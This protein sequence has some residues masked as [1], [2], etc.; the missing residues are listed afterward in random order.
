MSQ[1]RT[2]TARL[3]MFS[4]TALTESNPQ[5]NHQ[6]NPQLNP[7]LNDELNHQRHHL[8][9]QRQ[10]HSSGDWVVLSIHT[11]CMTYSITY[12]HT[13]TNIK[14]FPIIL[15]VTTLSCK[16]VLT[17]FMFYWG[18]ISLSIFSFEIIL[19]IYKMLKICKKWFEKNYKFSLH[20]STN[21]FWRNWQNKTTI[22][23]ADSKIAK[24]AISSRHHNFTSHHLTQKNRETKINHTQILKVSSIW[25]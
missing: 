1:L 6:L 21:S 23:L 14:N 22:H 24:Y 9:Y 10:P 16:P 11:Y 20:T 15:L 25:P 2:M 19:I 5:L 4:N 8:N 12:S 7:Q 18:K 17:N 13:K 3:P